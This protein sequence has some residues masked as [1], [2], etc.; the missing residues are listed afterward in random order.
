MMDKKMFQILMGQNLRKVRVCKNMTVEQ[1]ALEAGLTYSQVS[2][3]GLGKIN[4]TVYTIHIL[5]ITLKVSPEEFF[6]LDKDK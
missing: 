2:R 6:R 5:S 1:L 3:I 4:T